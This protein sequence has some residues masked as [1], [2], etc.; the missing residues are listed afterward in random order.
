MEALQHFS[1]RF[2]QG[3]EIDWTTW[4]KEN[5]RISFWFSYHNNSLLK[6]I[7][8]Q[9]NCLAYLYK[10]VLTAHANLSN[11]K[12]VVT[13]F[14]TNDHHSYLKVKS[15][16]I[17]AVIFLSAYQLF[18]EY[19]LYFVLFLRKYSHVA[20]VAKR[21]IQKKSPW[22]NLSHERLTKVAFLIKNWHII[23]FK[24]KKNKLEN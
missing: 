14:Y 10:Y 7:F 3:F 5:K 1:A 22:S 23:K 9:G 8:L 12:K 4:L 11:M 2:T 19:P 24:C 15:F 13:L 20:Y 16:W 18:L 21:Q 17:S 6:N